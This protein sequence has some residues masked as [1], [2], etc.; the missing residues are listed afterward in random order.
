MLYHLLYPLHETISVLNV[1]RY[2]T[3]R[4]IYASVTGFLVC[5]F[6][7]PWVIRKLTEHQIGEFVR[8]D[9]P[10]THIHKAGTPTMGGILIIFA[11]V[12]STLLWADLRNFYIWIALM[13]TLSY[14]LIGFV[15]DYLMQIKKK[16]KGLKGCIKFVLQAAIALTISGLLYV[17][18]DFNTAVTIPF[19]KQINP[20]LGWGYI[21]FSMLIIVGTSNAVNLTDGLDGLAIGPATVAAATY[22]VFAY[23]AGHVKIAQYL[24]IHYVPGSGELAVFCGAMI[25]AGMGFLW[26]NAYPASIFMGNVGSLSLGGALGI[27]AVIIKQEILLVIV[28]GIFVIETL[29]VIFQVGY[30]KMTKGRRIFRMAPL[31]HHFE[32]RGWPEPKVIIRF[33]IIAIIL[34]LLSLSTLKLR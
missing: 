29:S 18:S 1:F 33:W 27:V 14:G 3:F 34:G 7:G 25:G 17:R 22:L 31:H 15:D 8:E 13:I 21:L 20:D 32:L 19:F 28:G 30:F 23:V 26:Y 4:A 5:F 16:S 24:H 11:I 12:I 10:P 2:I 6:L 9:G